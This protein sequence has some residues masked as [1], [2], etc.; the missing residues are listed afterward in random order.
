MTPIIEAFDRVGAAIIPDDE[1]RYR[2][3]V[4]V[5]SLAAKALVLVV[6]VYLLLTM[7][8]RQ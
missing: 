8:P 6:A 1:L 4:A 3:G 7:V 2:F 5:A